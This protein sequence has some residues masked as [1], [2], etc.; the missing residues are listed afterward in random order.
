MKPE[1]LAFFESGARVTRPDARPVDY[2]YARTGTV[3]REEVDGAWLLGVVWDG[4]GAAVE[5]PPD[6]PF[7]RAGRG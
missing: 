6:T 5:Y 4:W 7:E 2:A 1:P 3:V